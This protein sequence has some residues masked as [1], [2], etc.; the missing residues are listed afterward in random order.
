M[1]SASFAVLA[2][3][4]YLASSAVLW[5]SLRVRSGLGP[6]MLLGGV[7]LAAHA[8]ALA[9]TLFTPAGLALDVSSTASLVTW[10]VAALLGL[11]VL[12]T[13]I[14]S[15]GLVWLP[16]AAVGAL[17]PVVIHAPDRS[18][19]FESGWLIAHVLLS[20]LA[21]GLL[22]LAMVQA[23]AL[24]WQERGLRRRDL[25]G[26][27]GWLPPL[28]VMEELLFQMIAVGVGLLTVALAT[29]LVFVEDVRGQHLSHKVVLSWLAWATFIA[30]LWGRWRHGWR[31]RIAIHWT[32]AGVAFLA[33]AYFGSR[34]VLEMLLGRS[35][36]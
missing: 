17:T 6:A 13:P 34:F 21:Y 5:R 32:L 11:A 10:E 29:G 25:R 15:L 33:L 4:A 26:V 35:W 14:A 36:G 28:T 8:A 19:G 16:V 24:A 23:L 1:T 20:L 7:A 3:V 22:T 2:A 18:I 30:L 27:L 31:G 9:T 12:R